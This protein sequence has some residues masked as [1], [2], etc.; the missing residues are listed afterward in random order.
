MNQTNLAS[1]TATVG[2]TPTV[3]RGPIFQ[4]A[5]WFMPV[6]LGVTVA[7]NYLDRNLLPLSLPKIAHEFGWDAGAKAG[8]ADLV[9]AAFFLTYG[10]ANIFLTPLALRFGVRR[11]LLLIVA[12]FSAITAM[13]GPLGSTLAALVAFRL[14]LGI[15]EGV[16]IPLASSLIARHVREDWRATAN[17]IW[18]LGMLSASALGPVL[19]IAI[20]ASYGWR[21]SFVI[22]GAIGLVV[23]IPLILA[24]IPRDE[25]SSDLSSRSQG[26]RAYLRKSA[27]WLCTAAGTFNNFV[28]FGLLNWL[29]T[30]FVN[31]KGVTFST[32]LGF[33]LSAIALAGGLGMLMWGLWGDLRGYRARRAAFAFLVAAVSVVLA[34]T[35][36]SGV[37]VV[38]AFFALAM[39]C[40]S[41]FTAQEYAQVQ[42]VA[43][44]IEA[45]EA[46][47][48]YNG[49]SILLGGVGGS[50]VP[51]LVVSLVGNPDAGMWSVAVGALC[52]AI[53][54]AL[55]ARITKY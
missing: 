16:H 2:P 4:G 43:G 31:V 28:A 3:Y 8:N 24:F 40:Q 21:T 41:A 32:T 39:F 50:L 33:D 36:E 29:P 18:Q 35:T 12:A 11:S 30:Y 13:V 14:L 1:N 42:Y 6:A 25:L 45:G 44:T 51:P 17:S 10:L 47:G 15:T 27:F 54:S 23:S 48:T 53:F 19:L 55:V 9:L 20:V 5:S 37:G 7:V 22:V 49:L 38:V 34:S 46:T 26:D 52:C